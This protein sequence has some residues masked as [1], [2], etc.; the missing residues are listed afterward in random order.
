MATMHRSRFDV[1]ALGV[2]GLS[3]RGMCVSGPDVARTPV[4]VLL[5]VQA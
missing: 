5:G 1:T 3:R 4:S 2:P